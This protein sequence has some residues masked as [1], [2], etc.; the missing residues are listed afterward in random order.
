MGEY[1]VVVAGGTAARIFTLEPAEIPELQSGPNLIER[2]ALPGPWAQP[3]EARISTDQY[4]R[5]TAKR[6]ARQIALAIDRA[7]DRSNLQRVVLCAD[8]RLLGVLRPA[9]NG[10][11]GSQVA[12]HE[13]PKDLAKLNSRQ[14]HDKLSYGGHLPRRRRGAA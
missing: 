2:A 13:V 10:N 9:L 3:Q 7:A 14:L 1:C 4:D 12:V 5:A 11:L 8:R 6:F